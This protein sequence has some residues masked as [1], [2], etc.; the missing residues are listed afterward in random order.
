MPPSKQ[1][2]GLVEMLSLPT[3]SSPVISPDGATV[4]YQLSESDWDK[5]SKRRRGH[6]FAVAT[7]GTLSLSLSNMMIS[8]TSLSL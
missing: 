7:S 2:L 3:V 6:L 8:L 1:P 4:C 5:S